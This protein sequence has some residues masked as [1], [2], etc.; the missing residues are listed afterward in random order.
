MNTFRRWC[1]FVSLT[2][3][4]L[5]GLPRMLIL[6]TAVL[7]GIALP[8][9]ILAGLKR[10]HVEDLSEQLRTSPTGRE[11]AV[12]AAM[13]GRW[14]TR[15]DVEEFQKNN[16]RL[17]VAIPD[18]Q[19][20]GSIAV[21]SDASVP[22][23][24]CDITLWSTRPRDPRL[25]FY[26]ADVIGEKERAVVVSSVVAKQLGIREGQSVRLRFDR[27]SSGQPESQELEVVVKRIL[28]DDSDSKI[29]YVDLWIL[30]QVQKFLDGARVPELGW[31]ASRSNAPD[32]Y[33]T[34]LIFTRKSA[35]LDVRDQHEII[36]RGYS[37]TEIDNDSDASLFGL[38]RP[39]VANDLVCHRLRS[40][41][42]SGGEAATIPVSPETVAS[43]WTTRTRDD[44]VL[45]WPDTTEA[46]I[47]GRAH[48]LVGLMLTQ[49]NWLRHSALINP[50]LAF[51][52]GADEL[53][54]QFPEFPGKLQPRLQVVSLESGNLQLTLKNVSVVESDAE[55]RNDIVAPVP[56]EHTNY[57]PAPALPEDPDPP[58]TES[59]SM[60]I[61]VVPPALLAHLDAVHK[62][63]AEFEPAFNLFV[64]A[65][66]T[67]RFSRLRIYAKT[68]FDVPFVTEE[69]RRN[70]Y[71]A[72]SAESQIQEILH[73]DASLSLIVYV[74][75]GVVCLVCFVTIWV[76]L[77]DSTERKRGEIGILRVMG[78]SRA[79]IF[80]LCVL[81]SLLILCCGLLTAFCVAI[82]FGLCLKAAG[83]NTKL[84]LEDAVAVAGA[85][86]LASIIGAIIPARAASMCDPIETVLEGR[87]R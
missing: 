3:T 71:A 25:K 82:I 50:D 68:I 69:L 7:G 1:F 59:D 42:I 46:K 84:L 54:V 5:I 15:D 21:R 67:I 53:S 26:A 48:R 79:G 11:I 14:L 51:T 43:K 35:P 66:R 36:D 2:W 73:Q 34:Y 33:T 16:D 27:K 44:V 30:E 32:F 62:Q 61:A 10:G 76:L 18:L 49:R 41:L 87:F 40:E 55:Y 60:P 72:E 86:G 78:V 19:V 38:I 85:L 80:F 22:G 47:N 8:I 45:A 20:T 64:P 39:D 12:R 77:S 9:L 83:I 17:D 4:D 13:K 70:H 28:P 56:D 74:V 65:P 23:R 24:E 81:R 6:Q 57:P 52:Y 29:G 31:P 37:I 63:R 58:A 75:A